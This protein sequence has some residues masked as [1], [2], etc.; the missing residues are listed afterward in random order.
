MKIWV[1]KTGSRIRR[2]ILGGLVLEQI[3]ASS[4]LNSEDQTSHSFPQ[5]VLTWS[6]AARMKDVTAFVRCTSARTQD[7][8]LL[9]LLHTSRYTDTK[10][11]P[12]GYSVAYQELDIL[13]FAI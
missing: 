10:A 9:A 12:D 11:F 4:R 13:I 2:S 8:N 5:G 6:K 3:H 1:V 7:L